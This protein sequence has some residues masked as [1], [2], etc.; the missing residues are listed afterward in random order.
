LE[1]ICK[2]GYI[3]VDD[4]SEEL[5][6]SKGLVEHVV[7]E[8]KDKGYLRVATPLGEEAS[9][10]FCPLRLTC[11]IKT[12]GV[13]KSYVLTNKGEKLLTS[14]DACMHHGSHLAQV[15]ERL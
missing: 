2:K 10:I 4:I 11:Q 6:V 14:E 3:K 9:C 13:A 15:G 7:Q 1:C 5:S 12:A 8:L